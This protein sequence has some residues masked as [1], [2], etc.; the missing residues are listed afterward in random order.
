MILFDLLNRSTCPGTFWNTQ[1]IWLSFQTPQLIS[2]ACKLIWKPGL[3]C[4]SWK[5]HYKVIKFLIKSET[6]AATVW[7]SN[8][9]YTCPVSCI[10]LLANPIAI[11][12][13]RHQ[14]QG[15][16]PGRFLVVNEGW[17]YHQYCEGD[18]ISAA[19]KYHKCYRRTLGGL[20]SISPSSVMSTFF[21]TDNVPRSG[22]DI[23]L[24][25]WTFP[26]AL[27]IALGCW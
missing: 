27:I 24:W 18:I 4:S 17:W 9:I 23:S 22:D 11:G 16:P 1:I 14:S 26:K 3:A 20:P 19:E 13:P 15:V 7:L 21:S 8:G 10:L 5:T 6:Q 25:Y 2:Y 12:H